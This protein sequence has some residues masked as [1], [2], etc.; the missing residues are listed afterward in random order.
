MGHSTLGFVIDDQV[1]YDP[2]FQAETKAYRAFYS[3]KMLDWTNYNTERWT[4]LSNVDNYGYAVQVSL[5]HETTDI[6]RKLTLSRR[7]T[8]ACERKDR[9]RGIVRC[10]YQAII[11]STAH[12]LQA[13]LEKRT[14]HSIMMRD[15]CTT[16]GYHDLIS[17]EH[18]E[19]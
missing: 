5:S 8:G 10:L 9:G 11:Q 18:D 16:A 15:L 14:S 7:Y 17:S 13:G 12:H 3:M 4:E 1:I 19:K 6:S 2:R